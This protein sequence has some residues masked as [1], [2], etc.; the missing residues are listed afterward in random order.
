[1]KLED[2][3]NNALHQIMSACVE[4]R[5]SAPKSIEF[6]I[7]L[8]VNGDVCCENEVSASNLKLVIL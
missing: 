7:Q 8:N 2:F 6:N 3:L 4:N 1:M 5:I